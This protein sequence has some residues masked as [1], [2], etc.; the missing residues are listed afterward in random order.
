MKTAAVLACSAALAVVAGAGAAALLRPAAPA[1]DPGRSEDLARLAASVDALT[2]QQNEL[3]SSLDGLSLQ[4]SAASHSAVSVADI[5]AAVARYMDGRAVAAAKPAEVKPDAAPAAA[6]MDPQDALEKLLDPNLAYADREALW[7]KI[8]DAGLLDKVIGLMEQYAAAHPNDPDAQVHLGGAYLQ[9]IFQVGNGPEAGVWATKADKAF[10]A[11]L[12]LN[13]QH[14]DA[15]FAKAVSLSFWPPM[16][17][18]QAEAIQNFQT[19][20]GQQEAGPSKPS[21]SQTYL[22][23]GN[24]YLQQGK[25]DLAKQTYQSGLKYFPQD[26]ALLKQMGMVQ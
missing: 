25:N 12:A 8:R 20:I 18:K 23:L 9:K 17:G 26:E 7:K 24:L 22:W 4:S 10:D 13:P 19:L 2:R 21:Y 1:A 15:R 16:F 5:D 6:A 11:A 14:W 3:R